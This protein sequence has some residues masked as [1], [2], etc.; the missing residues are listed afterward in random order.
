MAGHIGCF[1]VDPYNRS[2]TADGRGS[3]GAIHLV[4][5][6][7]TG[8]FPN[9]API[10]EYIDRPETINKFYEDVIMCAVFFG[11]P[12]LPELSIG[13]FSTYIYDR[14]YRNFALNNPF[15]VWSELSPEEKEFGG[16][17]AQD[18][19]IGDQQMYKVEY[20]VEYHVGIARTDEYR[21]IGEMG[22]FP[23]TRTLL[24]IKDVDTK[25]RTKFDAYISF[26]LALLGNKPRTK[27]KDETP[28]KPV[29]L[30]PLLNTFAAVTSTVS[31]AEPDKASGNLAK[32]SGV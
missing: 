19:K 4:T 27:I 9:E 23:F 18:A 21:K 17:P 30:K 2:K 14:G 26:S 22:Y 6:F 7:N 31:S 8:P 20:Y 3:K 11:V 32:V 10:V 1:G 24:Q 12:F 13:R 28:S 16:V 5:K 29:V 25:N 15:K